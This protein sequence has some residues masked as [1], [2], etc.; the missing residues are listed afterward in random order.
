MPDEEPTQAD[1]LYLIDER[2][3]DDYTG[4][5]HQSVLQNVAFVFGAFQRGQRD[6][7]TTYAFDDVDRLAD[8]RRETT[9]V[10]QRKFL[11][12]KQR[13]MHELYYACLHFFPETGDDEI[14]EWL[15]DVA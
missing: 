5:L 9:D 8:R 11:N 2:L 15:T 13:A 14:S 7:M 6:Q 10:R 12:E 3:G 4:T 1:V